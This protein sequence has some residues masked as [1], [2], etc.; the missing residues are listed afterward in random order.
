MPRLILPAHERWMA[1]ETPIPGLAAYGAVT[2]DIC[3]PSVVASPALRASSIG[4]P[5]MLLWLDC[6]SGISGDMLLGALIDA[7]LDLD[8]LRTG[9][10]PLP[11]AGYTLEA[12]SATEHGISGARL[13]VRLDEHAPHAH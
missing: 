8:A 13:H 12:E 2:P 9:L 5:H 6:F 1:T 4:D 3:S 11:L 7:G 10:A